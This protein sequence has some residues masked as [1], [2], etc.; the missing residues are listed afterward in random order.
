M[1]GHNFALFVCSV[2]WKPKFCVETVKHYL[3]PRQCTEHQNHFWNI[4]M[5]ALRKREDMSFHSKQIL[6]G[7]VLKHMV[8]DIFHFRT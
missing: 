7:S 6:V 4:E 3:H 2:T 8:I 1:E 5:F